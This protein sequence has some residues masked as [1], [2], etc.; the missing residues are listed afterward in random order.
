MRLGE[1]IELER[2]ALVLEQLLVNGMRDEGDSFAGET[3]LGAVMAR[4]LCWWQR[5]GQ[6]P[7]NAVSQDV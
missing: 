6:I 1:E 7:L 2:I 5:R 3:E 4:K